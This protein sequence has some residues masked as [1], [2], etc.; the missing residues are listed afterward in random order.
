MNF[1]EL[2]AALAPNGG[3]TT[4][5][6]STLTPNVQT[7]L[8][9]VNGG[10][11][12]VITGAAPGPQDGQNDTVQITG[13]AMLFGSTDL[14][15]ELDAIVDG[16]GNAQLALSYTL[17]TGWVF[18]QTF[19]DL[20]PVA[21]YTQ[22]FSNP[23]SPPFDDLPLT[24]CRFILV[25]E[26]G[27]DTVNGVAL[28]AGANFVGQLQ[29]TGVM[30]FVAG[31]FGVSSAITLF[32]TIVM[33]ASTGGFA[34]LGTDEPGWA[35]AAPV[36]GISLQADLGIDY[37][38]GSMELNGVWFRAYAPPSA[39]WLQSNPTYVPLL[40]F[41]GELSVPS[42]GVSAATL[43]PL[44]LGA[45]SLLLLT[46][47]TGASL[48]NLAVLVDAVGTNGLESALPS[49][50]TSGPLGDLQLTF[51]GLELAAGDDGTFGLAWVSVTVGMPQLN[52]NIWP[53]Q[54]TVD[55]ILTNFEV[56]TPFSSPQVEATIA[57]NVTVEGVPVDV[58][59]TTAGGFVVYAMLASAQTIPLAQMLSSYA[60]GITP[61]S[62]LTIDAFQVEIA[63]G[64]GY[65][66]ALAMAE[67]PNPWVI[68]LGPSPPSP[69]TI[70]DVVM[71]F[72]YPSGGPA[73]GSIAG[74]IAF[75]NIGSLNISYAVPGAF[76]LR[77]TFEAVTLSG[78]VK[79]LTDQAV[80]LPAGFDLDF[81]SSSVLIQVSETS[82]V[83]QFGTQ[84]AG[85]GSF[86]LQI[87]EV[88]S[89]W[90][91]AAGLDLSLGEPSA[92]PGLS[93]LSMFES[94]FSLDEFL[95]VV[96][97]FPS[98]S[99]TFPA[100]A[101]FQ[102][103]AIT[104]KSISLPPQAS[105]LIAGLNVYAQWTL[106]TSNQQ[107]LLKQLLGLNP[108]LGITLQVGVDPA[109]NSRLYVS[110]STLIDGLP[111]TCEFGGQI[112]SGE[113]GLF[114][115]GSMQAT[116]QGQLQT[117]TV[118]LLF[119]ENGAFISGSMTGS[120]PVSFGSFSLADLAMEIGCDWEGIP[121][122]GI[123]G[124]IATTRFEA[125]VA[126]FFDSADPA[127]S[128]VAG[129]VSSLTLADVLDTFVPPSDTPTWL[130]N[131]LGQIGLV[132]T[133]EFT[134]PASVA[135][136]LDNAD[137]PTVSSAFA[138]QNV[139]IPSSITQVLIV[140]PDLD[141]SNPS[142]GTRWYLTDITGTGSGMRHYELS[143]QGSGIQ[144]L[145]SPQFYCAPQ[146][147]TIGAIS[148]PEGFFINTGLD[149][150]GWSATVTVTIGTS[151][152]A[153]DASMDA[154]VIGAS[155]FLSITDAT[156][157]AGPSLSLATFTQPNEP[158]QFQPPH[159]FSS[160]KLSFLGLTIA[161]L[162]A[163]ITAGGFT[164]D[165]SG[166][167]V[168]LVTFDVNAQFLSAS[169]F[170]AGGSITA[171]FTNVEIPTSVIDWASGPVVLDTDAQ[172]TLDIAYDGNVMSATLAFSFEF[173]GNTL[174]VA[175]FSLDVTTGPLADI[176]NTIYNQIIYR[177]L[178]AD[179]TLYIN[180]TVQEHNDQAGSEHIDQ[181]GVHTDTAAG[182]HTDQ[183]SGSHIDQ[184][185]P[186]V[187]HND[188]QPP[189]NDI[190]GVPHVDSATP[191]QDQA[192]SP[193]LD[194]PYQHQDQY[195]HCDNGVETTIPP[196]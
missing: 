101:A 140:N 167:L 24:A 75:A 177:L 163:D 44:G 76:V 186:G 131:A 5:K 181:G 4:V 62:D 78:L 125:S 16:S 109:T 124:T 129:S 70:S 145:F 183:T 73:A 14:P 69:L 71:S 57:G 28:Q 45:R 153:I 41:T 155:Y 56:I 25:T 146:T 10:Q 92:V 7:L 127:K 113:I 117:F 190:P 123:A 30:G 114:L 135:T 189:H 176:W 119:V 192:G 74:T 165:L 3:V 61:P 151:G 33:P 120:H 6:A 83:F 67:E 80:A 60:P 169:S 168:P 86:D 48:A 99:F 116:I 185:I 118:V 13:S 166:E 58:I 193:H 8:T 147:T 148:F 21:N 126:V 180:N 136:A 94:F 133:N 91:F 40:A 178:H 138:A 191:H 66:M 39:D 82:C 152:I 27:T 196:P 29:P 157:T 87:Q 15:V 64:V 154:I 170:S 158:P 179:I 142:P 100:I 187:T 195:Y 52:W 171:G 65:G 9:D 96:S 43:A 12:I 93:G 159:F 104:A 141:P 20:P 79:T 81:V 31:I 36:P 149:V 102:N 35:A 115:T 143:L 34:P 46:T 156:G 105:G 55:S 1:A 2:Q 63:P 137:M 111:L 38:I 17:P 128:L 54:F 32:G 112:Q 18:S 174:E 90:G 122:V 110:Y 144:V 59:A 161:E 51:L 22:T 85:L 134:I 194:T 121:S 103:P 182:G 132:G 50:I 49:T 108:T 160:G 130:Q 184:T 19:P 68:P 53:G 164:F 139:S 106:D 11:P 175:E 188:T 97:S 150:F 72:N 95:L 37:A 88:G 84:V 47:F 42:A 107:Q 23:T 162:Y 173:L 77:G 89:Q 172:G 26:A 98:P